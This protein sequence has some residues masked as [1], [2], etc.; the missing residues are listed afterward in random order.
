MIMSKI[1]IFARRVSLIALSAALVGPYGT[2]TVAFGSDTGESIGHFVSASDTPTSLSMAAEYA[3]SHEQYDKAIE[4]VR[5]SLRKNPDDLES[6]QNYAEALEGKL[7]DNPQDITLHNECV[8]EWLTVLRSEAGEEKGVGFHG[9]GITAGL[10][11]DYDRQ[12]V[13]RVHLKRLVGRT[14]RPWEPDE[15]YLTYAKKTSARVSA[16]VLKS[17]Q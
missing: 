1:S 17:D 11:D 5:Q 15:K 4:L 16:K 8:K 13:A 7:K 6:H 12:T 3:I 10:Y 2:C 9:V 14:P